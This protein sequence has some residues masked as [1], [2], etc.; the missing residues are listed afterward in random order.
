MKK[1]IITAIAVFAL[2]CLGTT[3]AA[4][5]EDGG[6]GN[7]CPSNG[8]VNGSASSGANGESTDSGAN[9]Y[10]VGATTGY[11]NH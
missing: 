10:L 1:S 9:G 6:L 7:G 3:A 8:G 5:T 11:S 4:T 2:T